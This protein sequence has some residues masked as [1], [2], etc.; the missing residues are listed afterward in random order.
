MAGSSAF[1]NSL[2]GS[3]PVVLLAVFYGD[4]TVGQFAMATRILLT[5]LS[6]VSQSAA[7]ANIGEVGRLLRDGDD[8]AVQVVRRGLRDLLAVG[9]LP[10]AAA[11]ATGAWVV[12][13]VLGPRWREAGL[14]LALLA[15][16]TLAQFVTSPFSQLLNLTGHNRMLLA[17]DTS[18]FGVTAASLCL[19]RALGLSPAWA[20]GSWSIALVAVYC[21]LAVMVVR[22]VAH[23]RH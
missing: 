7:S 10:C 12:P 15:A 11:A 20:I 16:G 9:L 5:P 6:L 8:G 22:V 17:W 14:L 3:L 1:I 4:A 13:F 21:A 23:R 18:R 2:T 19:T